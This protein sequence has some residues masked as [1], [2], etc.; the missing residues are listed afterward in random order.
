MDLVEL[1]VFSARHPFVPVVDPPHAIDRL[2]KLRPPLVLQEF[3]NHGGVIF[4]VYIVGDHV[5][6]IKR[7]SLPDVSKEILEDTS[8]EGSVSFSQEILRP[9]RLACSPAHSP[10]PPPKLPS[11]YAAAR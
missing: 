1:Q 9:S 4:K 11:P 7:R 3:V 6:C 10:P 2:R 5:T 8:A